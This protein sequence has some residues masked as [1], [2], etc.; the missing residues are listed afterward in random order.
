MSHTTG[1]A[2][3]RKAKKSYTLSIES[4]SFLEGLRKSSRAGSVSA[5]L[6]KVLK[7]ARLAQHRQALEDAVSGYYS[8]LSSGECKESAA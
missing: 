7:T 1:R 4:V 3:Q 8:S 6:E 5:V 2:K